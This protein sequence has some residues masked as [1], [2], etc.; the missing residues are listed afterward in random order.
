MNKSTIFVLALICGVIGFF[1][2][3]RYELRS[4]DGGIQIVE[5]TQEQGVFGVS[6]PQKPA[7][8]AGETIRVASFNI[9]VLGDS[10]IEKPHVMDLLSRIIRQFDV[11]AIQE[12]RSRNQDIVPRFIDLINATGRRYDYVISDRLGRTDQKEQY[13]FIFDTASIEIDRH[14]L[15]VINDPDD[16]VHREP[17]VGW[18]RARGPAADQAFT[19][20]LVNVHV[21]PDETDVELD[22]MD[23]VFHAVLRD[24]RNEDDVIILGDFNVSD[25]EMGELGTV[26]GLTSVIQSMPTNTRKTKQ[27]DNLVFE[28]EATSEFTG[29]GGIY[30]FLREYNLSMP[31]AL[32]V[33]DHLPVWAEF[34]VYEG[35]KPGQVARRRAIHATR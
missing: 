34:N 28:A 5:R 35:G 27:Y 23:D 2:F 31:H 8:H 18:F 3:Q 21:D 12:I 30:D 1:V 6:A 15:Y 24:G 32:E 14:Q 17:F 7:I 11:V 9:Q 4:I 16:V 19:F 29:R 13:A 22:A 20:S 10:K 25:A 33:S 26:P